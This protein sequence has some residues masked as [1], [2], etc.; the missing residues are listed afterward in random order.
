ML[1]SH[2]IVKGGRMG[3]DEFSTR[4]EVRLIFTFVIA[5]MQQQAEMMTDL[6]RRLQAT[7][8]LSDQDL[9]DLVA[10][11]AAS[12]IKE[13]VKQAELALFEFGDIRKIAKRYLDPP[14]E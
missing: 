7:G 9:Q 14:E 5:K 4:T 11:A 1:V 13:E 3:P 12:P 10:Q 6:L 2:Q 8:A